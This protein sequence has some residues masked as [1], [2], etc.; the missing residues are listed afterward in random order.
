MNK[1]IILLLLI[2][3]FMA[4]NFLATSAYATAEDDIVCALNQMLA[5]LNCGQAHYKFEHAGHPYPYCPGSVCWNSSSLVGSSN[6]LQNVLGYSAYMDASSYGGT[7]DVRIRYRYQNNTLY[8]F[9]YRCKKPEPAGC[10][11]MWRAEWK[12]YDECQIESDSCAASIKIIDV[13]ASDHISGGCAML[14]YTC[15]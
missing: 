6:D 12:F 13:G 10:E 14:S 5:P 4:I 7:G 8:G 1:K 15:E 11:Q 9:A 3:S 2:L